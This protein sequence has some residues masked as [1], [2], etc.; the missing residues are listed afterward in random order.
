MHLIL[1]LS[2][3]I[4]LNKNSGIAF[5]KRWGLFPIFFYAKR[6]HLLYK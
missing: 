1:I 6:Q 4:S 5:Y 2:K 3:D